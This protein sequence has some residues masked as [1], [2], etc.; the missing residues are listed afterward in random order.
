M[1]PFAMKCRLHKLPSFDVIN[2][3]FDGHS[4]QTSNAFEGS[5]TLTSGE[6]YGENYG[7][8]LPLFPQCLK[9]EDLE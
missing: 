2:L 9:R 8:K 6:N 1:M 4:L 5:F 3:L 7:E